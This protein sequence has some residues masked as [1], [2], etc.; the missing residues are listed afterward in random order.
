MNREKVNFSTK[1]KVSVNNWSETKTR[2]TS[3]DKAASD[4]NLIIENFVARINNV[5]VKYRLRDKKLTRETF[6]KAYNRPDD[7]A[8]FFEFVN[9]YQR[10]F[11]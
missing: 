9:E 4:K 1:V 3:Q 8:T 7:Y 5:F 2:V 6:L 10:K 11:S